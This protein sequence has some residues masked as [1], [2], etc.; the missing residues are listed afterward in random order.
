MRHPA[1]LPLALL[2][3]GAA[4]ARPGPVAQDRPP[5]TAPAPAFQS[6]TL[7]GGI[8]LTPRA[9]CLDAGQRR[10]GGRP[11][12][13]RRLDQLPQGDLSLAVMREV[14]GCPEPVTIRQGFGARAFRDGK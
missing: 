7:P 10:A 8:L 4:P 1:V 6:H 13:S 11:L 2:C 5:P 14:D 3:V 12:R 9:D